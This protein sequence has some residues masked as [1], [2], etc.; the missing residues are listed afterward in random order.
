MPSAPILDIESLLQPIPGSD[1]AG[2]PMP[3][4]VRNELNELRKEPIPNDPETANLKPDWA[5]IVRIATDTLTKKSKHLIV[6]ARLLE[7]L[8]KRDGIRGLRDGLQLLE[9]L[10]AE[11]WDRLHPQPDEDD[12]MSVRAGP[13]QWFNDR[14]RSAMLPQAVGNCPL[15]IRDGQSFCYHDWIDATKKE[16]LNKAIPGFNPKNLRNTYEDLIA[17][18][19]A[20]KNLETSLNEK[21]GV[22]DTPDFTGTDNPDNLGTAIRNCLLMVEDMAKKRGAPLTDEAAPEASS[23]APPEETSDSATPAINR[24][25]AVGIAQ[26]RDG[27]YRQIQ[28]IADQLRQL[29]PHSPIPYLLDR[30]V[31]MGALPFP[32]LVKDMISTAGAVDEIEK[33]LGI[34]KPTDE[35]S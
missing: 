23:A 15:V 28:Q 13:Y 27:L 16:E 25:S 22:E 7:A 26:N 24:S 17:A 12:G 14:T 4:D 34:P 6:A 19:D 20:L 2:G 31:R 32:Q 1:P 8:T 18:R 10:T 29:E 30:C 9:R 3:D 5:R 35:S 33:L 11:C 21:L